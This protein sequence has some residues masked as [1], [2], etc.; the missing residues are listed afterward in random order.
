MII[1]DDNSEK[2]RIPA[3]TDR[4]LRKGNNLRQINYTTAPLRFSDHRPVYATF[5]CTVNLID[6]AAKE[7][8]SH[9]IYEKRR[10]DVGGTTANATNDD[11]EDEDLIGYDA[12]EPGLPPASSDRRKWWLDNGTPARSKV[13]P[14]THAALPNPSRPA[15]PFALTDEPDWVDVPRPG[16]SRINSQQSIASSASSIRAHAA[17]VGPRKLPPPFEH[18]TTNSKTSLPGNL[19]RITLRDNTSTAQRPMSIASTSSKASSPSRKAAP[20]VAKKPVHLSTPPLTS[21]PLNTSTQSPASAPTKPFQRSIKADATGFPPPPRRTTGHTQSPLPPTTSQQP[22][23]PP[24]ARRT[25]RKAVSAHASDDAGPR[26]P[27]RPVDLLSDNDGGMTGWEP[28]R[29]A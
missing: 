12:I 14:P 2:S 25:G 9:E 20:P 19:S 24:Q 5:Q 7:S 29:P 4:I 28:L 17:D 26:L 16:P 1:N 23:A 3:W 10:V 22:P 11:T 15:N 21:A 18:A 6:D 8:L 27:P 13:Q